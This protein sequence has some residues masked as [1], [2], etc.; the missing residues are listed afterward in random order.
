MTGTVTRPQPRT[1]SNGNKAAR[2]AWQIVWLLLYRPSPQILQGWRRFLLRLFGARM[3]R[4][5]NAYPSVRIWAPWNLEM[6]DYSCLSH[7]VDC[8]CV[9]KV[10][11]GRNAT[12]SQYS[13]LCTAT[14]DF[15]RR[16]LP[17]MAAPIVLEDHAWV[18]A[19]VFVG[20]GVR[21]GEGAVVGAHSTVTRD[22]E[23]WTVVAGAPARQ[24]GLR[25]RRSF[26]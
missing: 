11:I 14:R 3:G 7:F 17:L 2:A 20:P 19:A 18:T 8:Y 12:V 23:P 4:G 9:D 26:E 25:D 6:Q 13:H 1:L 16:E 5:S 24:I 10:I 22:V 21:I 15:N